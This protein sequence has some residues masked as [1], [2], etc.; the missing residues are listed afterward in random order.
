MRRKEFLDE[1]HQVRNVEIYGKK[2]Y[3]DKTSEQ[4]SSERQTSEQQ[5]SEQE[6]VRAKVGRAN[7]GYDNHRDGK[8]LSERQH[9]KDEQV[10]K[11]GT[12]NI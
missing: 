11:S 7:V 4:Q 5:M 8:R 6:T 12:L 9:D 1:V 10:D 2:R 3:T